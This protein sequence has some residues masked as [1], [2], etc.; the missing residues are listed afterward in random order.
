M[1]ISQLLIIPMGCIQ[2]GLQE[3]ADPEMRRDAAELHL[4]EDTSMPLK[5]NTQEQHESTETCGERRR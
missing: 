2:K 1:T 4:C 5:T 3:G